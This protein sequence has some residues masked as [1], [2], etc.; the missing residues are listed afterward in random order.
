[1]T[2]TTKIL[3]TITSASTYFTLSFVAGA[4]AFGALEIADPSDALG[5]SNSVKAS[6][7]ESAAARMVYLRSGDKGAI[8]VPE[9]PSKPV[10]V[11]T[12]FGPI[13]I[14]R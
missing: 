12:P 7:Q 13:V 3:R 4:L 14:H 8:D 11:S 9:R 2:N 10:V 6:A 1:M 5:W